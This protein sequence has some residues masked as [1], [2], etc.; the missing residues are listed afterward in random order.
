MRKIQKQNLPDTIGNLYIERIKSGQIQLG[1]RLPTIRQIADELTVSAA[2]VASAIQ[3]LVRDGWLVTRPGSGCFVNRNLQAIL[4][5]QNTSQ[6]GRSNPKTEEETAKTLYFS[7]DIDNSTSVYAYLNTRVLCA[8][9]SEIEPLNRQL[10]ICRFSD[11]HAIEQACSAENT[12][13]VIY[14]PDSIKFPE[15][16]FKERGINTVLFGVSEKDNDSNYILPD[17]Y[18]AG[19]DVAKYLYERGHRKIAFITAF[20]TNQIFRD[21]HFKFRLNGASDFLSSVDAPPLETFFWDIRKEGGTDDVAA[22]LKRLVHTEDKPTALIV[23]GQLM[24]VEISR[25]AE[26]RLQLGN[27]LDHISIITFEDVWA[28][29]I[30]ELTY[31]SFS[32]ELMAREAVHLLQQGLEPQFRKE[33]VRI[34]IGMHILERGSVRTVAP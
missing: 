25:F 32:P 28:N 20:P 19:Y 17:N 5:A 24:A 3:R 2:T 16:I 11:K 14:M 6:S 10:K 34:L 22:L 9:Q 15:S 12:V 23:A 7:I 4:S 30:P 29:E 1:E 8:I 21:K 33:K 27:L 13:G 18:G 31:A 26:S